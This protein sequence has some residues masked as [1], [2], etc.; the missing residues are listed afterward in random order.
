MKSDRRTAE[1]LSTRRALIASIAAFAAVVSLW[2]PWEETRA[3]YDFG[4]AAALL[5]R[6]HGW[7]EW[8]AGL[9]VMAAVSAG[10]AWRRRA[11]DGLIPRIAT[12]LAGLGAFTI[13]AS[14]YVEI[15]GERWHRPGIGLCIG[16]VSV[17][18]L[19]VAH[20]GR[21]EAASPAGAT[22]TWAAQRS[23]ASILPLL[24]ALAATAYVPPDDAPRDGLGGSRMFGGFRVQYGLNDRGL[25]FVAVL[26]LPPDLRGSGGGRSH[27]TNSAYYR[28]EGRDLVTFEWTR[29]EARIA[30]STF[31]LARGRVVC[32]AVDLSSM[33]AEQVPIH[34]RA[35]NVRSRFRLTHRSVEDELRRI[36]RDPDVLKTIERLRTGG[37]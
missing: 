32:L 23:R 31:D 4:P 35:L 25:E 1:S 6:V 2:L 27:G 12:L 30:G 24:A 18:V 21:S 7:E 10:I 14:Q 37:S 34:P 36:A 29:D 19:I 11:R 26:S 5:R 3:W 16:L 15:L 28:F 22:R 8:N 17:G 13:G 9:G 33:R 20:E